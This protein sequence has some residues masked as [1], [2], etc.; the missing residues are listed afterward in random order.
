[1]VAD[2]CPAVAE[3]TQG[4]AASGESWVEDLCRAVVAFWLE[5]GVRRFRVMSDGATD[6]LNT[7]LGRMCMAGALGASEWRVR[8]YNGF[9]VPVAAHRGVAL[10]DGGKAPLVA[11]V[12]S[13]HTSVFVYNR[14]QQLKF[15]AADEVFHAMRGMPFEAGDSERLR[16]AF[17][18]AWAARGGRMPREV[19]D[20]IKARL[21]RQV[22]RLWDKWI[23]GGDDPWEAYVKAQKA[24]S[25]VGSQGIRAGSAADARRIGRFV[26]EQLRGGGEGGGT[27]A[28]ALRMRCSVVVQGC[29]VEI[30]YLGAHGATR[31]P[32]VLRRALCQVLFDARELEGI[33]TMALRHVGRARGGAKG[34]ECPSL[35]LPSPPLR[36][37]HTSIILESPMMM[38]VCVP[39]SATLDHARPPL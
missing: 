36:L 1:V 12:G 15:A 39:D 22:Q 30:R 34:G 28:Q 11:V 8:T 13:C 32:L 23:G 37:T 25:R 14:L 16:R 33:D 21:P 27:L 19:Y 10:P 5:V 17:S 4:G 38:S 9:S 29:D 31:P 3:P 24:T 18:D 6:V 2:L 20:A 35:S 26:E 7:V